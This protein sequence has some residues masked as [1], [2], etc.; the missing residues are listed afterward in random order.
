MIASTYFDECNSVFPCS[1]KSEDLSPIRMDSDDWKS[2]YI[3]VIPN[4]LSLLDTRGESHR[5]HAKHI[6]YFFEKLLQVGK[7]R[8]VDFIDRILPNNPT[9]VKAAF[10]HFDYWYNNE[11][12]LNLRST[13]DMS[14]SARIGGYDHK[15]D[16]HNIY[17]EFR[18]FNRPA[19]LDIK[20]NHKPISTSECDR[21]MYQVM[22]DNNRM[23]REIV[24]K[25]K[26]IAT[27][28]QELESARNLINMLAR[29]K[30]ITNDSSSEYGSG[31]MTK[32][33][34]NKC[35]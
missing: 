27:L 3:P 31:S 35:D 5:F 22:E 6:S 10:V 19:Y 25:N 9:P 32:Q 14:S 4:H 28:E 21:N 7:I 26:R 20:I 8:R 29:N 33:K 11:N 30:K 34:Y 1:I 13:L 24:D 12:A 18:I 17:C 15:L 23:E 2:I 16:D